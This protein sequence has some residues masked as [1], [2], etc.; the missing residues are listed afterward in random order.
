MICILSNSYQPKNRIRD[1]EEA[2]F[3][4]LCINALEKGMNQSVLTPDIGK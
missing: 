2:V 4:S 3:V 1:L